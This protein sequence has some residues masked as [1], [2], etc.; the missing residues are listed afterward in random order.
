MNTFKIP[1]AFQT[2][3]KA[4][5]IDPAMALRKSGLPLNLWSSGKGMVTTEQFFG[6]WRALG[7]L[8]NDP[9]IGLK[10]P[11]LVPQEHLH[12]MNIAAQHARNFRDAVQRM[13]RYKFSAA[14]KKC[15]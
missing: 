1:N 13:A 7:E 12:P 11:G 9:G 14:R 2:G 6:L 10:L 5:G 15:A 4:V 8:S 3:L